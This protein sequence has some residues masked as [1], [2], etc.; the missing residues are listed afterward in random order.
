M[1][2]KHD[3]NKEPKTQTQ[4]QTLNQTQYIDEKFIFCSFDFYKI[5]I[6]QFIY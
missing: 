3:L 4:T 6:T 2:L 1:L 5:F